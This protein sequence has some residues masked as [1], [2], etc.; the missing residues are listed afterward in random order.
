MTDEPRPDSAEAQGSATVTDPVPEAPV[1]EKV[2]EKAEEPKKL[3]QDVEMRDIGPCKK[4][5]KVTVDRADIDS[6]LH[7]KFSELVADANVAGFR[8]GKAPRKIVERRY[9][10]EVGEQVKAE[11]LYKSLEQLA[12][13]HDIAPLSPP[14]LDPSKIE[15]PEQG[16]FVYEFEVEVRPEF[17][18][19]DYKGLKLRRPV[20]TFTDEDIAVEE[21]RLL[22]QHGQIVPKPEGNAQIGDY[23]ITDLA[24]RDGDH[25]LSTYKELQILIEPRLVLKD[26]LAEHF[27]DQVK[28]ANAGDTRV[29]ELTVSQAAADPALRGRKVQAT[30]EVKEVKALRLPELTPEFLGTYGV[31]TPEQL[32]ERIRVVLQRRLEYLQQR[33]AREQV[34]GQ[35]AAAST[36]DLP[37]ELVARQARQTLGR[38]VMEMRSNGISEEEIRGQL[39]I[40]EQDALRTTVSALK[41]HFVLQ[42]IAEVEKVNIDEDDIT[43]EIDRIA[44]LN[45]ESP[46][47]IRARLEK[48]ELMEALAAELIERKALD[49][50]L[51]NA[52]Y[53]ET[54]L[55]QDVLQAAAVSTVEEQVVPGKM[56]DP[57][58]APTE[59]ASPQTPP[60]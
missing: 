32:H 21:R 59:A 26:A 56:H 40:L 41:E 43:D 34:L 4:Y 24:I 42:K 16:P 53:E 27:G 33:A 35:I 54:P 13:D 5:I 11:V 46:R 39:R 55:G 2:E 3:H 44:Y 52:E 20:R 48:E 22:A 14:K 28:G 9:R 60:G 17:D 23:L 49:L 30:F 12:D 18:L 29:V 15:L 58:A 57:T 50:V 10:K 7:E 6:S 36:W 47:R 38:R 19:P 51:A 8:P 31:Q 37:E 25:V 45:N 1:E